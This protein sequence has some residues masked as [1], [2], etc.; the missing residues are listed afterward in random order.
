M[1]MFLTTI[2]LTLGL[3]IFFVQKNI[4]RLE[5]VAERNEKKTET[6]LEDSYP[7]NISYSP[8]KIKI[9]DMKKNVSYGDLFKP[10]VTALSEQEEKE[11]SVV[12]MQIEELNTLGKMDVSKVKDFRS[13]A[14][15]NLERGLITYTRD[16]D[17]L[18][19][20]NISSRENAKEALDKLEVLE[21]FAG[22]ELVLAREAILYLSRRKIDWDGNG[23][24]KDK[25]S[26]AVTLEAF[27]YLAKYDEDLA[28]EHIKS[29]DRKYWGVYILY[30]TYG[31]RLAGD[32][33]KITQEKVLVNF[34]EA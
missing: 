21:Y 32:D 26:L 9:D 12:K 24:L 2:I 10:E 33:D 28:I 1:K 30:F 16:L 18:S 8:V 4:V 15:K 20:S 6:K 23:N 11:F 7:I 22:G 14:F 13:V 3:I 17:R 34:G 25:T 31:R 5:P 19:V 27:E 29:L